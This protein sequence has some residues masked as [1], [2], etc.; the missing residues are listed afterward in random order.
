M[1][2]SQFAFNSRRLGLM[3]L[4]LLM[5]VLPLTA[6]SDAADTNVDVANYGLDGSKLALAYAKQFPYR[7]PGSAQETAAGD[8]I[9]QKFK[10]LG[11][12]PEVTEFTFNDTAG[13]SLT[14]RNIVVV[15]PGS[16]FTAPDDKGKTVNI[17]STV[18][19]GAHYDT[20]VSGPGSDVPA[21][22]N[23]DGTVGVP[24]L[25]DYNGI[26]D[27][28]AGVAAL[29]TIAQN[30]KDYHY[31]YDVVL[32]AFGAGSAGQAGARYYVSEMSTKQIAETDAMY[33]LD[34][35]YAGDKMYAHA[36]RNSV[37]GG[38][39]KDYEMRRKLYEVTDVFYENELYTNNYYMLYTNQSGIQV[40]LTGFAETVVYREWSFNDSDYLPFDE[41]KIPIV[42]F[43]SYEYDEKLLTEMTESQNPAFGESGGRIRGTKFDSSAFLAQLLNTTRA[44]AATAVTTGT[45]GETGA[46]G[47]TVTTGTTI[48]ATTTTEKVVADLLTRRINNTAFIILE[49]MKRNEGTTQR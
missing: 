27:N 4:A 35:I 8:Y 38:T 49:A 30:I 21:A 3:I 7:S 23:A 37:T 33:C 45:T 26:Q 24:T 6:C 43:E 42:F 17:E 1:Q 19:V 32:V 16:G 36:G 46:S 31:G 5:T 9:I 12:K 11:F 18:I 13:T 25:A 10:D 41:L 44:S 2:K 14:S 34:D 39:T 29:L 40:P 47:T 20:P 22:V 15:I 48:T 28:A